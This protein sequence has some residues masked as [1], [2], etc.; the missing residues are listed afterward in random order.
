MTI[1]SYKDRVI[2]A[3]DC[4][5]QDL[6][7]SP[8]MAETVSRMIRYHAKHCQNWVESGGTGQLVKGE[9]RGAQVKSWDGK[10]NVR[11]ASPTEREEIPYQAAILLADE[12]ESKITEAK[13]YMTFDFQP[14]A[15]RLG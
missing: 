3:F 15:K 11:F 8:A 5:G 14:T 12:I 6:C 9:S 1:D 4:R 10:V 2:L 7:M 13:H